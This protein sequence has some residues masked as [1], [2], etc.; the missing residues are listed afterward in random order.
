ME[1]EFIGRWLDRVA[2]RAGDDG[3]DVA[4]DDDLSDCEG[5]SVDDD[6]AAGAQE[7]RAE[8][9]EEFQRTLALHY[10]FPVIAVDN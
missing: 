3:L 7:V 8:L 9:W 6:L 4:S 2:G 5:S 1:G 10:P